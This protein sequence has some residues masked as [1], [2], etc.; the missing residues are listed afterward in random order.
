VLGA[1]RDLPTG[2]QEPGLSGPERIIRAM[3]QDEPR[4]PLTPAQ[5]RAA[6]ELPWYRAWL[7]STSRVE[8]ELDPDGKDLAVGEP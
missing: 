1:H 8:A 4:R 2:E 7:L 6:A 3:A 5:R